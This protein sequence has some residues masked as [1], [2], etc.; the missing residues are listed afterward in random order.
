MTLALDSYTALESNLFVKIEVE[1][2]V[3]NEGDTPVIQDLLFSDRV[4]STDVGGD[5]YV[6]LGKLMNVTPSASELRVSGGEITISVS[7]VPNEFS[8]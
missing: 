7:G 8:K 6:G 5:T 1:Y 2:Y 4:Q 3:A